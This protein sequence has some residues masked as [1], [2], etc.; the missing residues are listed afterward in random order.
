MFNSEV[1]KNLKQDVELAYQCLN[2]LPADCTEN[3]I[4]LACDNLNAKLGQLNIFLYDSKKEEKEN[5]QDVKMVMSL[6]D[7]AVSL[8]NR[9]DKLRK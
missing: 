8:K 1:Y 2:N 5:N 9:C 7:E 6:M 4:K 3:E